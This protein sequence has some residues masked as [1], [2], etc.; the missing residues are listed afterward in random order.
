MVN[1]ELVKPR[2]LTPKH[3]S[4]FKDQSVVDNYKF[5]PAYTKELFSFLGSIVS[6]NPDVLDIGCGS[7]DL[8]L[9][10]A[11]FAESVEA[12]DFSKSMVDEAKKRD[13]NRI[14]K[15][16][17]STFEEFNPLKSKYDLI[18][19]AQS[20]HWMDWPVVFPK[21]KSLLSD[22]GY[23]AIVTRGYENKSWWTDDLTSLISKYSTNKDF[24]SYKLIDEITQRGYFEI[25]EKMIT[26][27]IPFSQTVAELISAFQSRN[28]LSVEAMG[29]G[30]S[31]TFRQE[32]EQLLMPYSDDGV[33]ELGTY[34]SVTVGKCI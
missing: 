15:W 11:S 21:I 33:M 34:S 5:R 14:V 8:S 13:V 2:G 31:K 25:K 32:M 3:A 19:S 30:A 20:L 27:T 4:V 16:N 12:V 22:K 17:H 29:I 9:G 26:K 10:L 7:G 24:E 28:G 6:S 18:T 1:L 23:M